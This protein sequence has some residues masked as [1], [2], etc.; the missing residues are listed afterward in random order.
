MPS[1]ERMRGTVSNPILYQKL[2][3][4]LIDLTIA[5]FTFFMLSVSSQS[6]INIL[7]A[8]ILWN[9]YYLLGTANHN[10]FFSTGSPIALSTYVGF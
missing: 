3:G 10:L 7:Y 2:V 5:D 8:P 6:I 4:S 1:L 9:M